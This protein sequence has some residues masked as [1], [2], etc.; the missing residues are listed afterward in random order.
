MIKKIFKGAM[1]FV[2]LGVLSSCSASSGANEIGD[3]VSMVAV[4]D[5]VGERIE[6]TVTESEY[7]SGVHWVI[8][9]D[10]TAFFNK[11]GEKIEKSDVKVGDKVEII[12]SGQVMMSYPPQI[13]ARSVKVK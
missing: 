7:T 12:Y 3:G 4:V 5:A 10:E 2:A 13:V 9:S 1:L 6:V 8:T 11:N